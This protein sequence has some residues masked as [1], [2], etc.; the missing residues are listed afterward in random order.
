M[1]YKEHKLVHCRVSPLWNVSVVIEV[2]QTYARYTLPKIFDQVLTSCTV[3]RLNL[4][5]ININS[6]IN[7][8]KK[9]I[10]KN[11]KNINNHSQHKNQLRG[12]VAPRMAQPTSTGEAFLRAFIEQ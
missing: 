9:G 6:R 5:R 1:D 3:R 7:L 10:K 2:A 12:S 8:Y 4:E 11:E